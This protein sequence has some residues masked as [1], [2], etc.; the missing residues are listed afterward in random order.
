MTF[1]AGQ[2]VDLQTI[3]K[4]VDK[5]NNL[6]SELAQNTNASVVVKNSTA[7]TYRT[8][9]ISV[10]AAEVNLQSSEAKSDQIRFN[11]SFKVG[12]KT[13]PVVTATL[14]HTEKSNVVQDHTI[15]IDV[16]TTSNV[17]GYVKFRSNGSIAGSKINIIAVGST[18][19]F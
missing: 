5:V 12:Y 18:T 17:S 2:P 11:H 16:I 10:E 1:I 9:A 14:I 15:V 13:A 7:T 6:E 3:I 19:G 8:S 4:T